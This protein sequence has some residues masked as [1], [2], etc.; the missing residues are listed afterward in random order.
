M[1]QK[2]KEYYLNKN[3]LKILANLENSAMIWVFY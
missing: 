2:M 1:K 3:I